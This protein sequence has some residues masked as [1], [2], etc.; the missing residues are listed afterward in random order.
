M[1]FAWQAEPWLKPG[2][3][4]LPDGVSPVPA[5][6]GL[7]AYLHINNTH[8]S[9]YQATSFTTFKIEP[10]QMSTSPQL[11]LRDSKSASLL[12]ADCNMCEQSF[13]TAVMCRGCPVDVK[14]TKQ[15]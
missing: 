4:M 15:I 10:S 12:Q 5:S 9:M 8:G 13:G 6:S 14:V 11:Q 3:G 1:L 7:F 2:A